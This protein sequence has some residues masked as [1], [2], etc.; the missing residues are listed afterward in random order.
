MAETVSSMATKSG[1]SHCVVSLSWQEKKG[2]ASSVRPRSQPSGTLAARKFWLAGSG[3]TSSDLRWSL[4]AAT[5]SFAAVSLR[6]IV[7]SFCMDVVLAVCEESVAIL[8]FKTSSSSLLRSWVISSRA[9]DSASSASYS[10]AWLQEDWSAST[11]HS[12]VSSSVRVR[13]SC[14]SEVSAT[15]SSRV[16]FL[17]TAIKLFHS[18]SS[19]LKSIF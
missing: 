9:R 14:R 10:G 5:A 4:L 16:K 17:V 11:L 1:W 18:S 7:T 19:L 13:S 2:T 12:L 8:D 3:S 15:S 6:S